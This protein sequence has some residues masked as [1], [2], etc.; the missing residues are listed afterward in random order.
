M[1][2][3]K[4]VAPSP[5]AM[6]ALPQRAPSQP[7]GLPQRA[8]SQPNGLPQRA[9]S[10]PGGIAAPKAASPLESPTANRPTNAKRAE[11]TQPDLTTVL[12]A[13]TRNDAPRWMLVKGNLDHGPFSAR[14]LVD[15]ILKGDALESHVVSNL[16]TDE[17][18]PLSEWQQFG[19]FV[20]QYKLHKADH[21]HEVARKRS[22]TVESRANVAKFTILAGVL[23]VIVLGAGGY[24]ASRQFAK[25][26][27]AKEVDLAAMYEGGQ[28]KI[29]GTAG[30]LTHTRR[31]GGPSRAGGSAPRG[32]GSG[33]NFSSY[34]DAMNQVVD[35]GGAKQ[36][37]GE[38]QLST[39]EI[40]GVMNGRLNSLF[41]CVAQ[42]L[43]GGSRL[44]TVRID[45]AI[46]GSGAVQGVSVTP[47]TPAFQNCLADKIKRVQFPSFP[48][49]R[50]G[51]RYSFAVN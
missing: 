45:M 50:M 16:D 23:G 37:G 7:N 20:A 51:A 25:N 43:H 10:Q 6:R 42:E 27:A 17:R 13:I 18:K 40:E 29:T 12:A 14:E 8:P 31:S 36:A 38:K 11:H 5:T 44:G 22:D 3:A 41:G 4:P 32:N 2:A 35:L 26:K 39:R 9:H 47:G 1:A 46:A 19:E 48:A 24:L 21:D 28:V 34:E 49:P 15:L 33:S 30:I